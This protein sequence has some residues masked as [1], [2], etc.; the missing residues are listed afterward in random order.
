MMHSQWN[1]SSGNAF[2]YGCTQEGGEESFRHVYDT[3]NRKIALLPAMGHFPGGT[4]SNR[5]AQPV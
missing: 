4:D 1:S 2:V 3:A 5:P